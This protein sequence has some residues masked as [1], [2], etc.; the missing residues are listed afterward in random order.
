MD[1]SLH[2]IGILKFK[3]LFS[4]AVQEFTKNVRSPF[5]VLVRDR[6][7]EITKICFFQRFRYGIS[8]VRYN[9]FTTNVTKTVRMYFTQ[10]FWHFKNKYLFNWTL[11]CSKIL[12]LIQ[13]QLVCSLKI[14]CVDNLTLWRDKNKTNICLRSLIVTK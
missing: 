14:K 11:Q 13:N 3:N 7:F 10:P 9:K 4:P 6:N 5:F 12:E 8:F 2:I 1:D